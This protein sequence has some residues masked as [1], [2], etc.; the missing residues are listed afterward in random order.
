MAH[1]DLYEWNPGNGR[2]YP[3]SRRNIVF[4][5]LATI[6]RVFFNAMLQNKTVQVKAKYSK[7]RL[8]VLSVDLP[9]ISTF[10]IMPKPFRTMQGILAVPGRPHVQTSLSAFLKESRAS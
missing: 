10:Q 6:Q 2:W 7:P 3:I 9:G 1:R 4:P 5:A 8:H